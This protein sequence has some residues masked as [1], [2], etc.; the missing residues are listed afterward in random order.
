MPF[1]SVCNMYLFQV[2]RIL[3]EESWRRSL[4]FGVL[5][6]RDTRERTKKLDVRRWLG[7]QILDMKA[8][9]FQA[10]DDI[11]MTNEKEKPE[12]SST[13]EGSFVRW[14]K[15]TIAQLGYAINL[16][17]GLGTA[18]LGFSFVLLKGDELAPGC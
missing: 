12:K 11:R 5:Q 16:I 8:T 6:D 1:P 15:I 2:D 18:T 4:L 17:L 9:F 3:L 13:H 7:A 10:A 14:Q